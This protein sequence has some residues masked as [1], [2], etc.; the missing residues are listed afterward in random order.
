MARYGFER[1]SAQDMSFLMAESDTA[2]MHVGGMAILE[3]EPLRGEDGGVDVARYRAAVEAVLHRI[4][5]YRQRLAWTPGEGWAVWVDDRHFDIGYHIRHIGLPKPGTQAQLRELASRI[6]ARPLDRGRPLWEIWVVEGVEGGEQFALL[7]KIHHCMIDGAAGAGLAEILLSPNREAPVEETLPFIP[8]PEP[9]GAELLLDAIRH[10]ASLPGKALQAARDWLGAAD[11]EPLAELKR[12]ARVFSELVESSI[13]PASDTPLGGALSPDRRFG[14]L[15]MPLE[16]VKELRRE[17]GC[18]VNDIVLAT[19]AGAVERYLSRRRVD[20]SELDF[21]VLAPV[22]VRRKEHEGQLGNHVSSW[23]VPMPV[24]EADP[25]ERVSRVRDETAK[26]KKSGAASG[27]EGL[28]AAAEWMSPEMLARGVSL[29]QGPVN[30]IVTNVPGPQ[31]PLY[32]VGA[33]MLALYPAVPLLPGSG[34]GVALFSYEGRLCWGFQADAHLV[35]DLDA[36]AADVGAAFEE[37]R[38]SVAA[39]H[40]AKRTAVAEAPPPV[41]EVREPEATEESSEKHASAL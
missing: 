12:H 14:W 20:T 26:L 16:D 25:L 21:R 38:A 32:S 34:L 30:M 10:R 13:W 3:A 15:T 31:F 24:D 29:A 33:K 2:P 18:T 28:M 17:L 8:R 40:L 11:A 22:N 4:P 23:I 9:S 41:A 36:F 1:L 39:G 27:I 7:N 6:F 35:P 19:V 37:L 5:R